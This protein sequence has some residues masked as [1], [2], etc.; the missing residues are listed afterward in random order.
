M[1]YS[2][3]YLS[4]AFFVCYYIKILK[5]PEVITVWLGISKQ[6]HQFIL[7]FVV[8]FLSVTSYIKTPFNTDNISVLTTLLE[9]LL[10]G[11]F[12]NNNFYLE[13]L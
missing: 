7:S 12:I 13:S 1:Y 2:S 3:Q 4:W 11:C 5:P 10:F 6:K 9:T 8:I